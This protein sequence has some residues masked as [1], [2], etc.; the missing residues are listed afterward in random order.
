M[1]KLLIVL[2]DYPNDNMQI[3]CIEE[4]EFRETLRPHCDNKGGS[5]HQA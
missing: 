2:K 4:T 3:S 1:R 5:G